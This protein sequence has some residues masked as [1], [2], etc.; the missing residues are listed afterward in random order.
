MSA[1]TD[2]TLTGESMV[3]RAEADP[4]STPASLAAL[5]GLY[6]ESRDPRD[7]LASPLYGDLTGLPPVRMH[8]GEDDVLLDDS[9]RYGEQLERAG[10]TCQVHTWQGMPHVFPSNVAL[11]KAAK[12]ALDDV[13]GFLKEQLLGEPSVIAA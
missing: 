13:G 6:L 9:V 3:T 8:V 7:P 5:A 1:W 11:L 4:L 10:G 12:E 2:L